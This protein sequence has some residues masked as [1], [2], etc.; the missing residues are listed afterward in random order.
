MHSEGGFEATTSALKAVILAGGLGTRL[1]ALINDR[2]KS[3]APIAGRP[4]LEYQLLWLKSQGV[5]EV[6]LGVGYLHDQVVAHFGDGRRWEMALSYSVE[7]EPLGTAGAL[8]KA[9]PLLGLDQFIVMNGDSIV[10]MDLRALVDFHEERGAL[11]TLAVVRPPMTRRYGS[12]ELDE[13]GRILKFVEKGANPPQSKQEAQGISGGVYLFRKLV[14]DYIPAGTKVSLEGDVFPKL[15]GHSFYGFRS[16][17][18][19]IDIG[20][21]EDYDRAQTELPG[22]FTLC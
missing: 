19:F 10:E 21:P 15:V 4:F 2:P 5:R 11:A 3:M 17:G 22:K 14:L 13:D 12:I 18:Y 8:K 9:E 16:R 7:E 6:I 1:R 20:V